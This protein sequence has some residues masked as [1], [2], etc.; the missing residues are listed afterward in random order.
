MQK[1]E[2]C[3][4]K[5]H[6]YICPARKVCVVEKRTHCMIIHSLHTC[7]AY[8]VKAETHSVKICLLQQSMGATC[9]VPNNTDRC[10]P[11]GL[12]VTGGISF[13]NTSVISLLYSQPQFIRAPFILTF[14]SSYQLPFLHD[15]F[16]GV[17]F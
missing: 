8:E 4:N 9:S 6:K 10:I 16:K 14:Q 15:C 5:N 11:A 13:H 17:R 2:Q 12:A 7:C 3:T 1:A